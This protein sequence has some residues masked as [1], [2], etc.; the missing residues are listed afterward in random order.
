[1][2]ISERFQLGVT[3]YELDFVDIDTACDTPLFIDPHFLSIS[4]DFV[5]AESSRT[6][7]NFFQTF[8]T[9]VR[10]RELEQARRLFDNLH[11]P[12]ETCLGLSK[13][14]PR[15]N[16]IGEVDG[17]K[18][19]QSIIAS[20]AVETGIVEDIED[21]RLFIEG[22]DK[23]KISDMTTN[24]IRKHLIRYTQ[25]QCRLWNIPL[26]SN[27]Q[28]GMCW[29]SATRMWVNF[30]TDML[31]VN[32]KKIILTP[33]IMVSYAKKYT[34]QKYFNQFVLEFL[35][36][37]HL[38]RGSFLVQHR[39][40]GDSY[41]TKK[42]LKETVAPYSKE[43]LANFTEN[44]P[45]VFSDFKDWIKTS[46]KPLKNE[47]IVED[48]RVDIARYLIDKLNSIPPGNAAATQYHRVSVGILEFLLY[49]EIVSP[50]VEREI[51]DGRK[52]IDITFDNAASAGF[53]YRIHTT[54]QTPSQFIFV[55]CK[56]YTREVANPELDQLSGRFSINRGKFGLLLFRQTDDMDTLLSRCN[57]TYV[58]GRGIILPFADS[59]LIAMLNN[60]INGIF[61]PY[62][63]VFADKFRAVALR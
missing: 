38:R 54:Y 10:T 8:L 58:D 56:N 12:N 57:D 17:E 42:S 52:R 43:L 33:K 28:S 29:D 61:N 15:G 36:N 5:S 49:P 59:D 24:I 1:M 34:P 19:F 45:D 30:Y 14:A 63:Q 48:E 60:A 11:E 6:L 50:V 51:H 20:R 13:D 62:E 25:D 35:Q 44:H 3:Q 41:V 53:F 40:N 18:L 47:D 2:K 31:V 27:V 39:K 46:S 55:E 37:D 4:T 9:L 21:F 7:R 16:A 22:I 32:E 23:D 26:Q